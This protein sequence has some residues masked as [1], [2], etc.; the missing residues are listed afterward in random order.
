MAVKPVQKDLQ[1][2]AKLV[3]EGMHFLNLLLDMSCTDVLPGK[4][5]PLVDSVHAFED[6]K[7]AYERLLSQR[8][9]GKVVVKVD[10]SVE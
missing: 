7:K 4:I 9:T 8:A 3:E 6:T 1:D 5:R 10:P 2:F